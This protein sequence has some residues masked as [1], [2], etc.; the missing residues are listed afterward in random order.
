MKSCRKRL[1]KQVDIVLLLLSSSNV[2]A[3]NN[4]MNTIDK[5][6]AEFAES[7]ARACSV[8]AEEGEEDLTSQQDE[9]NALM[10]STDTLYLGCKENVCCWL[11]QKD[12]EKAD[13]G[14]DVASAKSSKSGS[15]SRSASSKSKSS[16]SSS[17][18]KSS[19]SDQSLRQKA[20]LAGLKAEAE[21][22]KKVKEAESSVEL[23]KIDAKIKKAEAKEKIYSNECKKLNLEDDILEASMSL[24]AGR[25]DDLTSH[26]EHQR[27]CTFP[28]NPNSL[29]LAT[30]SEMQMAMIDL[31]QQQSAPKPDLD[32]FSDNPLEY[33]YFKANFQVIVEK[34]IRDQRG[35]LTRLISKT[36]GETKELINDRWP[37]H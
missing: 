9:V 32:S 19:H 31:M 8:A 1:Q 34:S 4:E 2:D 30:T 20:K 12:K 36:E 15:R 5:T 22:I 13:D 10:E 21:A 25:H 29:D 6:Y 17:S 28:V 24:N 3:V 11:I 7:Y 16:H 26:K 14:S 35:R 33:L 37:I 18:K 23:S 27:D